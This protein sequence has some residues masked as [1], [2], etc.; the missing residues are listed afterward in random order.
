MYNEYSMLLQHKKHGKNLSVRIRK[1]NTVLDSSMCFMMGV[2][3]V[4]SIK[5]EKGAVEAIKKTI[6]LHD[7]M[8]ELLQEN[9][10]GPSWDGDIYLYNN[11]DLKAEHIQYTHTNKR[12]E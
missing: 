3:I 8:D 1:V 11:I 10:K 7:K 4:N 2:W 9:D 5:I 6:R 12:K